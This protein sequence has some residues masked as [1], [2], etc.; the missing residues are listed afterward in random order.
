MLGCQEHELAHHPDEI[1]RR[2]H[3]EDA[4]VARQKMEDYLAGR[5][6]TYEAEFRLRHKDGSYRWILARG[7]ALRDEAGRPIRFAGSHTDITPRKEA[8]AE[9]VRLHRT[10]LDTSRQ[11]GMAEVATGVLHNVGNVLNSVNVSA[12]LISDRLGKSRVQ[13][14]SNVA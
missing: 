5:A 1:T 9:L 14:L 13:H 10:L 12:L 6:A 3:P 8:E 11:A 2:L 7:A 4:A